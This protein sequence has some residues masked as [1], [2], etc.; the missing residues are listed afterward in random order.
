MAGF[1]TEI[2]TTSGPKI[3]MCEMDLLL[4]SLCRVEEDLRVAVDCFKLVEKITGLT[5]KKLTS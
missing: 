2:S 1:S 3:E 5:E 4:M